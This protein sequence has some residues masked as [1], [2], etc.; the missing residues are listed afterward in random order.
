[1]ILANYEYLEEKKLEKHAIILWDRGYH[2]L[3][4]IQ[5]I[6]KQ[7]YYFLERVQKNILAFENVKS[8]DEIVYYFPEHQKKTRKKE[9]ILEVEREL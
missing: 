3:D 8:D 4:L 7:G 5:H 1:M 6:E 2:S 9:G